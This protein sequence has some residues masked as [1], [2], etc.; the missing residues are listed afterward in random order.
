MKTAFHALVTPMEVCAVMLMAAVRVNRVSKVNIAIC[1]LLV[2]MVTQKQAVWTAT[3]ILRE[4]IPIQFVIMSQVSAAV[5]QILK[6]MPV[7]SVDKVTIA[8]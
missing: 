4:L 1:V 2:S 5:L 7:I 3:V 8:Q 6:V